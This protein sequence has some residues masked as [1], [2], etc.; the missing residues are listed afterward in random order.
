MMSISWE[1]SLCASAS[2]S[3]K[4]VDE[5]RKFDEVQMI[6]HASTHGVG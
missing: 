3:Q 5:D 2:S 6:Q 4:H 1:C